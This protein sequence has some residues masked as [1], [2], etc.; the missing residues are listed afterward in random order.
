[1]DVLVM[2]EENPDQSPVLAHVNSVPAPLDSERPSRDIVTL[3]G[4]PSTES[5]ALALAAAVECHRSGDGEA[6]GSL[7]SIR[8][9]GVWAERGAVG[10]AAWRDSSGQLV[11]RDLEIPLE[12]LHATATELMREFGQV[13]G[14][15][16]A[17]LSMPD[18]PE[19]ARRAITVSLGPVFGLTA[20]VLKPLESVLERWREAD[21]LA[22]DYEGE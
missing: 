22:F 2:L 1:M 10:D 20:P 6:A 18:W 15:L 8:H 7:E 13:I 16:V 3:Y 19:G 9:V 14:R 21:S 11:T 4:D 12:I 5:V 17:G